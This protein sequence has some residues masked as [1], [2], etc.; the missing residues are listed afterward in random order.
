MN[1]QPS[2]GPAI[3]IMDDWDAAGEGIYPYWNCC[4]FCSSAHRFFINCLFNSLQLGRWSTE[5][6]RMNI[7]QAHNVAYTTIVTIWSLLEWGEQC[8]RGLSISMSLLQRC[9]D[10]GQKNMLELMALTLKIADAY[11]FSWFKHSIFG[12]AWFWIPNP[13]G[14][15]LSDGQGREK[16]SRVP[17]NSIIFTDRRPVWPFVLLFCLANS[18]AV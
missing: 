17:I 7:L 1:Q 2:T 14:M 12:S 9:I 10:Q 5:V 16:E 6:S 8:R 4:T 18:F 13:T 3:L 11:N 15:T